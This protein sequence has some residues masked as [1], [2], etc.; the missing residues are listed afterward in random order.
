MKIALVTDAWHP[1][2]NGVVRTWSVVLDELQRAGHEVV[3]VTPDQYRT[4]PCPGDSTIRLALATPDG[5][6][7]RLIEAAPDVIHIATEGP[8]GVAA[9]RWCVRH[10]LAF[11]TSYHTH[12]PQYLQMRLGMPKS[13]TYA[14]VRRFHAASARVMVTT[15][16]LADEL[17]GHGI[18]HTAL[19]PRG[20]DA[21]T[22]APRADA[23]SI[24][25]PRP[26][27]IYVGRVAVEKSI[28]E[29][30]ALDVPGTKVVVGD[31]PAR[32]GLE[33]RYPEA[34]FAGWQSGADLARWYAGADVFV[35]PSRTDT[36][37]LV[38]LEA[39]AS[40]LP[41]AAYPVPG[42]QDVLGDAPHVACLDS[43]LARAVAGAV[44]LSPAAARQHA[45]AF[46]WAA[47]AARFADLTVALPAG[48]WRRLAR[49]SLMT[50]AI[51]PA[52]RLLAG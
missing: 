13:L 44:R 42:P 38:L 10:G 30:L 16:T 40:G 1:Q 4:L 46:S 49:R 7:D 19:W 48:T 22:F 52:R 15:P 29:F 24:P 2:I 43:D 50:R 18:R 36:Y 27:M 23:V 20:V 41:V 33:A 31:G 37:G 17:A 21:R 3:T 11:T 25:G 12:F 8:L 28:E 6:G 14:A 32:R 47:C 9:R 51:A 34:V 26:V 35:F 45:L 5:V 39:L